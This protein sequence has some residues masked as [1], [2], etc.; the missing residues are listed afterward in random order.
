MGSRRGDGG[1]TTDAAGKTGRH[2][3]PP[4]S[5]STRRVQRRLSSNEVDELLGAYVAG[6]LVHD[7]AVRHGVHR[8]TVIGH[9][10]RRGLPRRSDDGRSD[11]ELQTAADLHAAGES[12]AAIGH[13]FGIDPAIVADRFRRAG[14]PIRARRGWT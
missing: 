11:Q 2:S 13:H 1:P 4:S 6:D 12:L 9:V 14:I 8:S 7:I 3:N 10:T 5:S